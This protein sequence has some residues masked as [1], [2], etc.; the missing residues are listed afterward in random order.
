MPKKEFTSFDIAAAVKELKGLVLESRVNNIYQ[1]GPKTVLFKLHKIDQPPIRLVV[2]AGRRLHSTVYIEESPA[3]PPPFC[4]MLRQY[5]RG[6][7]L[8]GLEQYEFERIIVLSF[9]TKT[10]LLRLIVELFGDGNFILINP[11]NVII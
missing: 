6:A 8:V 1:F 3:E 9:K 10:G 11:E 2:E 7:W 5:L 4:M